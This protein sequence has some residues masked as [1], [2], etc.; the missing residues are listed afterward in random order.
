MGNEL[1]L[2]LS[3]VN[4]DFTWIMQMTEWL[5]SEYS[6]SNENAREKLGR[7]K[8]AYWQD[9]QMWKQPEAEGNKR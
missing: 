1:N 5:Y 8:G 7:I 6:L 2:C 3:K 9:P 4:M